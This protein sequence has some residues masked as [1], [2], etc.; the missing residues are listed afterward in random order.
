MKWFKS[1]FSETSG[2]ACVEIALCD[3]GGIAIRDSVF[4]S[5]TIRA[6]RAA[7]AALVT[8]IQAGAN[9]PARPR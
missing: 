1:S 7:L 6:S 5:R 2:N 3:D 4:P 9:G 8:E